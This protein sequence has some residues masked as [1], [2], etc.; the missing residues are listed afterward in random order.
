MEMLISSKH[1]SKVCGIDY[2][3][4]FSRTTVKIIYIW[5]LMALAI[6]NDFVVHQ[7]DIKTTFIN[8]Y[9]Y[10][11]WNLYATRFYPTRDSS[12]SL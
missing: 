1:D 12:Q 2:R 9:T 4:T 3:D 5:V 10:K 11:R 8:D 6:E 7:M